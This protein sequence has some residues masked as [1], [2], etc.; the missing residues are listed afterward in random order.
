M[1]NK[2][3]LTV[4]ISLL[5]LLTPASAGVYLVSNVVTGDGNTDVLFQK[6]DGSLLTGGIVALGY[7]PAGYTISPNIADIHTTISN[8][9]IVTASAVGSFSVSLGAAKPGYVEADPFAGPVITDPN[10]L[11]WRPLY[12]FCG[13]AATLGGSSQW[14]IKRVATIMDDIP[15][16]YW[17]LGNPLDG[18]APELGTIGAYIGNASGLAAPNARVYQ[19]LQMVPE[20]SAAL[21]GVFGAFSLLRRRRS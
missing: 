14:A 13:D 5:A 18:W 12:V 15:F 10:P 6:H 8:F 4:A 19:T 7:F 2:T 20:A 9:S 3:N 11:I 17:Y 21:L 16:E 1:K